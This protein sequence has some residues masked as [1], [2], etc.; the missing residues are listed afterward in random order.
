MSTVSDPKNFQGGDGGTDDD[1][2][3]DNVADEIN[4]IPEKVT[5]INADLV[6]I[7]DSADSNNKKKVQVG[8]LPTGAGGDIHPITDTTPIVQGSVDATKLVR[9]E[10]DTNITTA[11]TRVIVMA[12]QDIDLTPNTGTFP[13]V[14]SVRKSRPILET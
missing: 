8:N 1:A 7:E 13:A 14:P 11:N 12:D 5:P 6:I 2:I 9:V 4:Q 10:A 3:H